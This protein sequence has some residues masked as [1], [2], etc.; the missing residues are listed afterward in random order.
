MRKIAGLEM[1]VVYAALALA[2][3]GA[4]AMRR[5]R[6][7][8]TILLFAVPLIILYAVV[9]PNVGALHRMRYGYLM[10]LVGLGSGWLVHLWTRRRFASEPAGAER[11]T[12]G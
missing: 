4:V 6:A 3:G 8:Q 5:E 10:L 7:L 2:V 1:L 12:L 9:M 11:Q